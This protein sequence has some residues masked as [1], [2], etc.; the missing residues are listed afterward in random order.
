MQKLQITWFDRGLFM[1][2]VLLVEL[3]VAMGQGMD[4]AVLRWKNVLSGL[5][6]RGDKSSLFLS[7]AFFHLE[8]TENWRVEKEEDYKAQQSC[9]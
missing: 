7:F 9:N 5:I 1:C 2:S 4:Y 8:D 6:E 3:E